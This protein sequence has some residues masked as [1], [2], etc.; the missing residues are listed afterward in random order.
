MVVGKR[1]K[2]CC[3]QVCKFL[4]RGAG[5]WYRHERWRSLAYRFMFL[6]S[7]RLLASGRSPPLHYRSCMVRSH[8]PT[9]W[10]EVYPLA[11]RQTQEKAGSNS[12]IRPIQS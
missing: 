1:C 12:V 8:T 2:L 4:R 11:K 7:V 10:R 5:G 9:L 6:I 3:F